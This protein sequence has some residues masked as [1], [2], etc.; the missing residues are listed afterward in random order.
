MTME[1]FENRPQDAAA[2]EGGAPESAPINRGPGDGASSERPMQ[3]GAAPMSADDLARRRR[4]G[5][6]GR[7]GGQRFGAPQRGPMPPRPFAPRG[8]IPPR[9]IAPRD[10][11]ENSQAREL[12]NYERRQQAQ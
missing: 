2:P 5:R 9:P 1:D 12:A 8:P 4:R 11:E 3:P 7:G 6:R 10:D